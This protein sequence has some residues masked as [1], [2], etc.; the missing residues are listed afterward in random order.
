LLSQSASTAFNP[1]SNFGDADS[2]TLGGPDDA[3]NTA[4]GWMNALSG[5]LDEFRVYSKDLT[6]DEAQALYALE[7]NGF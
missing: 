7:K 2:F 4:N 6:S 3:A 1:Q 5:D